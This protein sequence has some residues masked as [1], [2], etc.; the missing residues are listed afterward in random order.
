M[1]RSEK[2]AAT[3]LIIDDD[4]EVLSVVD[5]FLSQRGFKVL[6]TSDGKAGLELCQRRA[7]DVVVTDLV[8]PDQDGLGLIKLLRES[9]PQIKI[10]AIS[11]G[12]GIGSGTYL[13]LAKVLG[14]HRQLTKPVELSRL[15]EAIEELLDA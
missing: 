15:L 13:S 8:M 1:S 2:R 5:R 12:G 9:C 10:V 4:E 6:V 11:G 7:P 14:A 3:V